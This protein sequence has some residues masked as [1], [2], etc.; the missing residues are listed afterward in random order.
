MDFRAV[1]V[2]RVFRCVRIVRLLRNLR[3]LQLMLG[4]LARSFCNS[5]Y[6]AL[7]V[8]ILLS[9]VAHDSVA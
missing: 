4:V 2:F 3:R 6:L 9:L 8:A 5:S 1:L 7:L